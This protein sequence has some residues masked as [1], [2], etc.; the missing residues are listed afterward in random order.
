MTIEIADEG[1]DLASRFGEVVTTHGDRPAVVAGETQLSYHELHLAANRLAWAIDRANGGE[2]GVRGGA[3]ENTSPVA[4]LCGHNAGLILAILG[5]LKAGRAYCAMQPDEPP[6]RLAALLDYLQAELIICDDEHLALAQTLAQ[7]G[8]PPINVLCVGQD[9]KGQPEDDL[10]TTTAPDDLA[11]VSFTSGSTGEPK[12]VM[13]SHRVLL[14]RLEID[15]RLRGVRW[16]DRIAFLFAASFGASQADLFSALLSGA[17]L[18]LYDLRRQGLAPLADWVNAASLTR[19]HLPV[20]LFRQWLEILPPDTCFP[21]LRE[22]AP[23]GRMFRRDLEKARAHLPEGCEIITRLS[24]GE[25][26]LI[27]QMAI[28]VHAPIADDVIPVG[29]VV[30]GVEIELV[31]ETGRPAGPDESDGAIAGEIIVSSRFLSPGYWRRPDLT[32]SAFRDDGVAANGARPGWRRFRTGDWGRMRPDGV[33]EFHGRRDERVKVRG[34]T[35]E[36]AAVE[37]ALAGLTAVRSAAVIAQEMSDGGKRLVAFFVP[38]NSSAGNSALPGIL[39]SPPTGPGL[40][41]ALAR[42]L[43]NYMIPSVFVRLDALPLNPNNKVDR[44]SLLSLAPLLS[45]RPA[46]PTD[47]LAPRNETEAKL[48]EVWAEVLS[49][50]A[51]GVNDDFIELGGNSILAARIV[52]RITRALPE[53][54]VSMAALFAAPTVAHMAAQLGDGYIAEGDGYIAE[55][56]GYIAEGVSSGTAQDSYIAALLAELEA[57]SDDQAAALGTA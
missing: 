13:R 17:A 32:A 10:P 6:P 16:E 8:S 38:A 55:G 31:D 56:N 30:P 41:E 20:E 2:R 36:M 7:R 22:V 1:Q 35:V 18:C 25:T 21:T 50:E 34:H 39:P 3:V 37:A 53:S 23:A 5:V 46:L 11:V 40:R 15:R 45:P 43:P 4:L 52:A 28:D 57:L 49:L 12:G 14:H 44:R 29:R 47:Y 27:A 26:N 54:S 19:L 9:T 33:L 42:F 48:A 51:V 24:S